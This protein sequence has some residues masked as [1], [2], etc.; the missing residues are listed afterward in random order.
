MLNKALYL[1]HSS[2]QNFFWEKDINDHIDRLRKPPIILFKDQ[3]LYEE[4]EEYLTDCFD[5]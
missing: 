5:S 3:V 1:K 4:D 2:S